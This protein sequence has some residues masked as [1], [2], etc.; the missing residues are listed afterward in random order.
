[1]GF[2][3]TLAKREINSSFEGRNGIMGM[4]ET[5]VVTMD[6]SFLISQ[7]IFEFHLSLRSQRVELIYN[8][9]FHPTTIYQ[10]G[11]AIGTDIRAPPVSAT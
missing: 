1:M 9:T 4:I 5:T 7:I 10:I 11:S 8:Y 3:F 2:T 6:N